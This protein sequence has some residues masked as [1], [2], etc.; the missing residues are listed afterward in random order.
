MAAVGASGQG[1]WYLVHVE[2]LQQAIDTR[3]E[4]RSGEEGVQGSFAVGEQL[5]GGQLALQAQ[6]INKYL[7][8]LEC[9][10]A[11]LLALDV[12][13]KLLAIARGY[14]LADHRVE[15]LGV[16]QQAVHI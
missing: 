5:L 10:F 13:G 12:P 4:L 2:V 6:L 9:L 8:R 14:L 3:H 11:H 1:T 7:A 15:A 16:Q